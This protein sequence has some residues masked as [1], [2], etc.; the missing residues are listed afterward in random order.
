M[1]EVAHMRHKLYEKDRLDHAYQEA[2]SRLKITL[3]PFSCS[4]FFF[5]LI[6]FF[7]LNRDLVP[8]FSFLSCYLDAEKIGRK[9]IKGSFLVLKITLKYPIRPTNPTKKTRSEPPNTRRFSTFSLLLR[10]EILNTRGARVGWP[11]GL[12]PARTDPCPALFVPGW[13]GERKERE[14]E[15]KKKGLLRTSWLGGRKKR[16]REKKKK[17]KGLLCTWLSGRKKRE[18]R[19]NKIK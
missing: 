11:N 5:R 15:K 18:G 10:V 19:K 6:T 2:H 1:S 16:E 7:F 9:K 12:K 4:F 13:V 17:K 8:L 14:R 3:I